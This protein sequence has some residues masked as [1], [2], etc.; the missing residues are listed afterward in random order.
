MFAKL[1]LAFIVILIAYMM[2][3]K[4]KN[5]RKFNIKLIKEFP[6][7]QVFEPKEK[8]RAMKSKYDDKKYIQPFLYNTVVFFK[9][10]NCGF[11]TK[12]KE[13]VWDIVSKRPTVI[14]LQTKLEYD[15][16]DPA[17]ETLRNNLLEDKEYNS[18]RFNSNVNYPTR[19]LEQNADNV[20][21][22]H[23]DFIEIDAADVSA[24]LLKKYGVSAFPTII[25]FDNYV[26]FGMDNREVTA[27]NIKTGKFPAE[28]SCRQV[29]MQPSGFRENEPGRFIEVCK[30]QPEVPFDFSYF[31]NQYRILG[32]V[33]LA[34][35]KYFLISK[36]PKVFMF[37]AVYDNSEKSKELKE[38]V[39]GMMNEEKYLTTQFVEIDHDDLKKELKG[40]QKLLDQKIATLG[41]GLKAPFFVIVNNYETTNETFKINLFN[42]EN[43][44]SYGSN[45]KN[46][47]FIFNLPEK[48]KVKFFGNTN[49][50][51]Y[52]ILFGSSVKTIQADSL[53]I[54]GILSGMNIH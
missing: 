7:I 28:K 47:K 6:F 36:P 8:Y 50:I 13:E 33:D 40:D 49:K 32:Y 22:M 9:M 41:A 5:D 51:S 15:V 35:F 17:Y 39:K 34:Y 29:F 12:F 48:N 14:D 45:E 24:D 1:I 25:N 31:G 38:L 42:K 54:K 30:D 37:L 3:Q 19:F 18:D 43:V 2:V 26:S 20:A 53:K 46:S 21:F 44:V 11:C 16:G 27:T 23:I 4:L 52:K 10:K